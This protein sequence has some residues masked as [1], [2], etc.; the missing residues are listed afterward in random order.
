MMEEIACG[1]YIGY[2]ECYRIPLEPD[3]LLGTNM[4]LVNENSSRFVAGATV[5]VDRGFVH[6]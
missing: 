6:I 4:W 2:K 1:G 3:D 5:P